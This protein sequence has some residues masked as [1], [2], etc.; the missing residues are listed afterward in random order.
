MGRPKKAD[1]V[2]IVS[3]IDNLAVIGC[4]NEEIAT[5]TGVSLARLKRT[6]GPA[7]K[8]GRDEL[9]MS[10]RRR[11]VMV[12]EKGNVTM[13]IWLGK[14]LLGQKDKVEATPAEQDATQLTYSEMIAHAAKHAGKVLAFKT[15]SGE[16]G[17]GSGRG[18]A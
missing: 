12:A 2:N 17:A 18:S 11:Q 6:Y 16:P 7:I 1:A 4:T 10:L 13:L 8:K 15:G 14:Q 9:R 3:L 5:I